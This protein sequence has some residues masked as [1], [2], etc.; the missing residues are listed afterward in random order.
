M[1]EQYK[2]EDEFHVS[3]DIKNAND[4]AYSRPSDRLKHYLCKNHWFNICEGVCNEYEKQ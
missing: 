1:M 3:V 4:T 2:T